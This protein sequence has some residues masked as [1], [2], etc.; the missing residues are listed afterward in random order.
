MAEIKTI[1]E[2]DDKTWTEFKFLAHKQ[3]VKLG[4]L[5][6]SLVHNYEHRN[7]AWWN[8]ILNHEKILS[9]KEAE[10]FEEVSKRIRRE[11]GFRA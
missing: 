7:A 9:D 11:S 10:E 5:F 2:V 3:N 8:T 1:K 6:K 4:V